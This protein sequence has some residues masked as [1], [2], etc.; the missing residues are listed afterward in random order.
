MKR[1]KRRW[2]TPFFRQSDGWWYAQL[3][4]KGKRL[5][6]RLIE[7]V[8]PNGDGNRAEAERLY[9]AEKAKPEVPPMKPADPAAPLT[10]AEVLDKY[11][12][13]CRQH[14][15]ERTYLWYFGCSATR[16]ALYVRLPVGG[17]GQQTRTR[18]G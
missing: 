15:A 2:N 3:T 10:A 9:F 7:G 13:W 14:K 17:I 18:L 11:L 8:G 4:V 5:Q 6:K 12:E 1:R 16:A